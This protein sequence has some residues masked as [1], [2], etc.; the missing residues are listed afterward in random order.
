MDKNIWVYDLEVFPNL[1]TAVFKNADTEE[2]KE[3]LMQ[4]RKHYPPLHE[5]MATKPW[6]VGFNSVRYDDIILTA[7]LDNKTVGEVYKLSQ[8]II[9]E[10][11]VFYKPKVQSLDLMLI[12]NFD[13]QAKRTSLKWVS[14]AMR[15]K[16]LADLPADP[17]KDLPK[18]KIADVL[19]YNK[20]DVEHTFEFYKMCNSMIA[21]RGE[22]SRLYNNPA[23]LNYSEPKIGKEI[24]L[25]EM[26]KASGVSIAEISKGRTY[27][28]SIRLGD[29]ISDK[30][31]FT[32]PQFNA[33]L[34][35]F[36]GKVISELDGDEIIL[37]GSCDYEVEHN[38]VTYHYGVG[39]L[40][41]AAEPRVFEST[42]EKV[43]YDFDFASFYP[44]LAVNQ[45]I[46]P[47]HMGDSFGKTYKEIYNKRRSYAKGTIENYMYKIVLNSVFGQMKSAYTPFYDPKAFLQITINGQLFLSMLVETFSR[48]GEIIQAN[49]DGVTIIADRTKEQKLIEICKRFELYTGMTLE[50]G[51]YDLF[52]LKDVNNYI[53]V[54]GNGKVKRKGLFETYED[55]YGA[56][57]MHKN[58][59]ATVIANALCKYYTE[60]VDVT[61]YIRSEKNIHEFLYGIKKKRNFE[62]LLWYAKDD[63]IY[64]K[65]L[66][67]RVVRY[68]VSKSGGSLYKHFNDGRITGVNVGQRVTPL[69]N[70]VSPKIEKYDIDYDFYINQANEIINSI[71]H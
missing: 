56:V 35:Y 15:S 45:G 8:Q 20:I 37:K 52:V 41:G 13:N 3:F 66:P 69:M 25:T 5:F 27:Y 40:H 67:Y 1:L 48:F 54:D 46:R 50:Y 65:K 23:F 17:T 11:R 30:I 63:I 55:I 64:N 36:K 26:S 60:G 62:Y 39:G 4:E 21:Q 12:N 10:D 44:L 42:T 58:P 2:V 9:E 68:F 29:C 61:E 32:T 31:K 7:I 33:M 57:A 34:E 6:L 71:K 38:G 43:I 22:L 24:F 16:N 14:Y 70:I 18:G 19:K 53:A 51:T 28:R 49:T 59:S 47:A